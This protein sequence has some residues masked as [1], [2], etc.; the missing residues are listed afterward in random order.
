M[1]HTTIF[2]LLCD[3]VAARVIDFGDAGATPGVDSSTAIAINNSGILNETLA[4]LLPGDVLVIPNETYTL[5][6]GVL[7]SGLASVTLQIDG[8]L[9]FTDDID[10]WPT[11]DGQKGGM[12]QT[13][14]RLLDSVVRSLVLVT[15]RR[16]LLID[17][18]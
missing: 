7:A 9:R 12:P 11:T 13:A 2:F 3:S 14:L 5:M 16:A 6:G 15:G 4:A 17:V 8:T 1:R 10:A 18:A